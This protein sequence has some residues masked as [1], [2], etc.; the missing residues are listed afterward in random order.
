MSHRVLSGVVVALLLLTTAS[1][2]QQARQP[3]SQAQ[4]PTFRLQVE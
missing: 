1:G 4:T 2:Q 3:I